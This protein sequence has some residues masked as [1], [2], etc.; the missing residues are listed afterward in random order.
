MKFFERFKIGAVALAVADGVKDMLRWISTSGIIQIINKVIEAEQKFPRGG[1]GKEKW[2][3]VM[4]WF[5]ETFPG[6]DGA[7]ATLK[8]FV[9]AVVAL[10]N[11]VK[12][13]K[14]S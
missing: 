2:V 11:I 10:F 9:S 12:I 5:T 14:T 7:I 6:N 8:D 3:F 13:F 4:Q 1:S